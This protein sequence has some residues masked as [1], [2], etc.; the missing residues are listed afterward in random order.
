MLQRLLARWRLWEEALER[1]DDP[2]GEYLLNLEERVCRLEREI[3]D[4][5]APLAARAS[6]M[7][8]G[9]T[10]IGHDVMLPSTQRGI[11]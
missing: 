3:V 4:L 9:A 2:R 11:K 7:P 10:G 1:M 6:A 5:R 8:A